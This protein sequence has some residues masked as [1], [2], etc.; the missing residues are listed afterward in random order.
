[1]SM[2]TTKGRCALSHFEKMETTTVGWP[3][4]CPCGGDYCAYR[5]YLGYY[6]PD[7]WGLP[8]R[9]DLLLVAAGAGGGA[10]VQTWEAAAHEGTP[11]ALFQKRVDALS[12]AFSLLTLRTAG[13]EMLAKSR[14]RKRKRV[15]F[16][17]DIDVLLVPVKEEQREETPETE[18]AANSGRGLVDETALTE[19]WGLSPFPQDAGNHRPYYYNKETGVSQWCNCPRSKSSAKSCDRCQYVQRGGARQATPEQLAARHKE[20][21]SA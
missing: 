15:S 4:Q 17:E 2:T 11:Q 16:S 7:D 8:S 20:R 5:D 13:M 9:A 6:D 12:A 18:A 21:M 3:L 10:I 1:M 19:C 14:D